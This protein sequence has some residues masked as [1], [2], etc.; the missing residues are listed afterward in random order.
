MKSPA[1]QFYPGDFLSDFNVIVMT[2]QEVGAYALLMC[3]CWKENGI[4]NDMEELATASRMGDAFAESW[5]KRIR[6]CFILRDDGRWDHPRLQAER[7]KQQEFS[8]KMHDA[9]LRRHKK[10]EPR[11]KVGKAKV[12]VGNAL[13]SSS[14][15]SSS[16]EEPVARQQRR[17]KAAPWMGGV[18]AVWEKH[19]PDSTP[20]KGT[21]TALRPLFDKH[22]E[23]QVLADFDA[24]LG[25]VPAQYLNIPK[26]VATYT[27]R[28]ERVVPIRRAAASGAHRLPPVSSDA[29]DWS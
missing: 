12:Q 10:G 18:N 23:Q 25:D 27:G 2:A 13:Q 20:P 14:S 22:P 5:E 28:H 3:V 24:M 7:V 9:A 21:A 26:W 4:T 19:Y 1:F 8:A 16:K 15:I 11:Q 17:G 6:R 29:I